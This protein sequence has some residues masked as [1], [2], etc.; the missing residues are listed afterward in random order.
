MGPVMEY[1][2][3]RINADP[4]PFRVGETQVAYPG[5]L[6]GIHTVHDPRPEFEAVEWVADTTQ[7]V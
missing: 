4:F 1:N 3:R 6:N 2:K 5:W 7:S